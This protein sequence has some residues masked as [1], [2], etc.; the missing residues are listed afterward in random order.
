MRRPLLRRRPQTRPSTSTTSS[1]SSTGWMV[2]SNYVLDY[3][4]FLP[5][6]SPAASKSER[7]SSFFFLTFFLAAACATAMPVGSGAF[8]SKP[9]RCGKHFSGS[10]MSLSCFATCTQIDQ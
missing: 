6:F 5:T 3:F 8:G 10:L 9:L 7:S 2:G 1:R 4:F